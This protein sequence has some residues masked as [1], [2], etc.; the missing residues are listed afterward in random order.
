[1]GVPKGPLFKIA[2]GREIWN[3]VDVVVGLGLLI[4]LMLNEKK[5]EE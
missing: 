5:R 1:M 2:L 3:T 4:T